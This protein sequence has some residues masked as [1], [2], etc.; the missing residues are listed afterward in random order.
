MSIDKRIIYEK[1]DGGIAIIIPTEEF[2]KKFTVEDIA[3][4]DVPQGIPY[5]IVELADI[6]DTISDRTFRS[7]WEAEPFE[8]D[9]FGDPD[10]WNAEQEAKKLEEERRG[11]RR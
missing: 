2:L 8:P 10:G 6:V 3:R 9:G 7:A 4:K 1:E 11:P 5:K